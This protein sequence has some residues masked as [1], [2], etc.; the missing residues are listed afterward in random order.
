MEALDDGPAI[1]FDK[2]GYFMIG[3]N[4]IPPSQDF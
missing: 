1:G 3:R 4:D 2:I